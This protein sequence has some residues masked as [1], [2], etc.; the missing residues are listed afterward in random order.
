MTKAGLITTAS[1]DHPFPPELALLP[2]M[3]GSVP[4][5]YFFWTP[6]PPLIQPPSCEWVF[7]LLSRVLAL[8]L[9]IH[10]C[11][12]NAYYLPGVDRG[13]LFLWWSLHSSHLL[14]TPKLSSKLN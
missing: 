13:G 2:D 4:G 14:P 9:F 5:K 8:P 1:G 10:K 3:L 7:P 12:L 6:L 11:L